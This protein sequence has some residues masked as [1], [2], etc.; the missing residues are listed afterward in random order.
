[1]FDQASDSR[2]CEKRQLA[3]PIASITKLMTAMLV[4]DAGLP[5]DEHITLTDE[6]RDT[7][8]GTSSRLAVGSSYTRVSCASGADRVG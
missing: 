7:L 3:T 5:M 8:K 2:C 6:D 1:V 4:L